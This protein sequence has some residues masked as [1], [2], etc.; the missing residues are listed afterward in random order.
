M[1]ESS[2]THRFL[3]LQRER[4]CESLSLPEQSKREEADTQGASISQA[5]PS[6]VLIPPIMHAG[7][8]ARD[9]RGRHCPLPSQSEPVLMAS[10]QEHS[11]VNGQGLDTHSMQALLRT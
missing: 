2:H 5:V 4:F 7:R 1:F 8:H 3:F 11:G 9:Q 10:M 6:G